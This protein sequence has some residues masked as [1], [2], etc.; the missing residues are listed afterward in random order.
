VQA[1]AAA[2]GGGDELREVD[3]EGAEELVG[4]VLGAEADVALSGPRVVDD[5]LRRT[6]GVANE[7][8]LCDELGLA[9]ARLFDDAL[10]L[11]LG[12]GQHLVALLDDPA[13]LLELFGDRRSRPVENVV[14]LRLV[15]A[16][17]VSQRDGLGAVD[18]IVQLVD[19][20]EDVHGRSRQARTR[21]SGA[22]ASA[23]LQRAIGARARPR[24][25]SRV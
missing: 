7:L 17:L 18:E 10:G 14:E 15:H 23:S 21:G 20:F 3:L 24:T 19:Q 22:Y 16:H 25:H 6:F 4:V 12:R 2:L 13:R 8:M 5:V 11:V 1:L 9:L